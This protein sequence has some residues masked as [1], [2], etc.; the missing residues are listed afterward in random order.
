MI[1]SSSRAAR[2]AREPGRARALTALPGLAAALLLL[3]AAACPG[4][5]KPAFQGKRTGEEKY[6][7]HE[8]EN[9]E[10]EPEQPRVKPET[11]PTPDDPETHRLDM[12]DREREA[13]SIVRAF[14][15][16]QK[17]FQRD[18]TPTAVDLD[19]DGLGEF[20]FL[21][22]IMGISW[23]R[24]PAGKSRAPTANVRD[25]LWFRAADPMG[26]LVYWH[27]PP[28]KPKAYYETQDG[29]EFL[30]HKERHGVIHHLNRRGIARRNG[31]YFVMYL[32]GKEKARNAGGEVPDGD[33]SLAD[34]MERRWCAYA[35]PVEPGVTG[36]RAFFAT[37]F[38]QVWCC[39]NLVARYGGLERVPAPEAAFDK[40]GP[41]PA[42]LDAL[43]A[44]ALD[45]TLPQDALGRPAC[46][47]ERWKI[48]GERK[49]VKRKFEWEWR[50]S[51]EIEDYKND[52]GEKQRWFE[53]EER[54]RQKDKGG[55]EGE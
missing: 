47:G 13:Y 1:G 3:F 14:S 6:K 37:G 2:G 5:K 33:P 44:I 48:F 42:N 46:D 23:L 45:P 26:R 55:E 28:D 38:E 20:G 54:K 39:W 25:W 35:W 51:Q 8:K 40:G 17:A 50:K 15:V 24:T 22:E 29:Y 9:G 10:K 34:A 52:G 19:G 16:A 36:R 11:I 27:C 41:N 43:P 18:I 4:P 30:V 49:G 7:P 53:G 32:P 21:L 12:L 31:Y